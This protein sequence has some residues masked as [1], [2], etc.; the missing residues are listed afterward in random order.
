MEARNCNRKSL[1]IGNPYEERA[2]GDG[3]LT[4]WEVEKRFVLASLVAMASSER[5]Y[6]RLRKLYFG[7]GLP[8]GEN[9]GSICSTYSPQSRMGFTLLLGCPIEKTRS[10]CLIERRKRTI[11]PRNRAH[12]YAFSRRGCPGIWTLCGRHKLPYDFWEGG[13]S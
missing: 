7:E 1:G 12:G 2:W 11:R 13:G 10:L 8:W 3:E 6:W 9:Y 4:K 5:I